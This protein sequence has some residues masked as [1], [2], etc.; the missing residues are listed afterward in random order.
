M[1]MGGSRLAPEVLRQ[2]L[3][4]APELPRFVMTDTVNPDAVREIFSEG[5]R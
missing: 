4:T 5:G 2:V 3:G 1:G